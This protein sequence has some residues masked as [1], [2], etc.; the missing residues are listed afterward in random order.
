M[1]LPSDTPRSILQRC[2]RDEDVDV[3]I[4]ASAPSD[5]IRTASWPT[6][7]PCAATGHR[8]TMTTFEPS[9]APRRCRRSK[10]R[11]AGV[12]RPTDLRVEPE[13]RRLLLPPTRLGNVGSSSVV[14]TACASTI[15][16]LCSWELREPIRL[17]E[18]SRSS[19]RRPAVG[20]PSPT[21]EG[22]RSGEGVRDGRRWLRGL[23]TRHAPPRGWTLRRS[24]RSLR[25]WKRRPLRR[26]RR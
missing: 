22:G 14:T 16:A 13:E 25:P 5:P 7:P 18:S 3:A 17:A 10:P 26:P 12:L 2:L 20:V 15:A 24:T 8:L 9:A 1:T 6:S 19:D 11:L 4:D 21:S 23:C